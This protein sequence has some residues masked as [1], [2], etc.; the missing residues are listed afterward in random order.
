MGAQGH[1]PLAGR[2]GHADHRGGGG[3]FTG[4][5]V[6]GEDLGWVAGTFTPTDLA[7]NP[8]GITQAGI[9]SLLLDACMNFAINAA[10]PGRARTRGT[11]EMKTETMR[12][13]H[14]GHH[15]RAAGRGGPHGQAGGLRRGDGARRRRRADQPG[16]GD[17]SPAST[18]TRSIT[19][20][21][22]ERVLRPGTG[23]LPDLLRSDRRAPSPCALPAGRWPA[24]CTC[25]WRPVLPVSLCPLPGPL[26]SVLMGYKESPVA[27][28]RRRFAGPGGRRAPDRQ[29]LVRAPLVRGGTL[30][31]AGR[32]RAP[33]PLVVVAAGPAAAGPGARLEPRTWSASW[34]H[35]CGILSPWCPGRSA[36]ALAP[37]GHMRPTRHAFE[38]PAWAGRWWRGAGC[39]CID[40]TYVSGARAQSAASALRDAGAAPSADRAGGSGDPA[41]SCGGARGLPAKRAGPARAA[42]PIDAPA[43]W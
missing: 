34:E 9:H 3:A 39:S 22:R 16:H 4:Y 10:L 25:P 21:E 18:R 31:G 5:G 19:R 42:G 2:R 37:V 24:A 40:D 29:F 43:V 17:L 11:L 8:H 12:P 32:P 33:G 36:T 23:G 28:V 38:V 7:C 35:R 26:Y 41:R 15:L 30:L 20:P 27:E 13:G 1:G 6:D 14:E